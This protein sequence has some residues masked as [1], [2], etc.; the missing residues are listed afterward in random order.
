MQQWA[1]YFKSMISQGTVDKIDFMP[2]MVLCLFWDASR[3]GVN[4]GTLLVRPGPPDP[5]GHPYYTRT[6]FSKK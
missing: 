1:E 6:R 2:L 5:A 3:Q 4:K